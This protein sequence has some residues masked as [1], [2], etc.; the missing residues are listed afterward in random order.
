MK[1]TKTA[2]LAVGLAM[3]ATPAL[4]VGPP[5]NPGSQRP[6]GT[7]TGTDNPGGERRPATPGPK[8][9]LPAKARAYGRYCN[10]QSRK[11]V[12]GEQGTPFSKCVTAMAKLASGA[13]ENP[14]TACK[15]ESK[16]RVEGEKGTPFSKCVSAGAKLLKDEASAEEEESEEG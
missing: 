9:G 15:T 5:D 14:R 8:A 10:T 6:A 11:R 16:K 3:M 12:E 2:A 4:A 13:V 1:T 7:P